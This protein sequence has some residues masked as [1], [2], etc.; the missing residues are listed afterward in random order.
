MSA[1]DT[2][3]PDRAL[4]VLL[5]D[6]QTRLI[7][8]SR[9][10]QFPAGALVTELASGS[11]TGAW[12]TF[13]SLEVDKG[14]WLFIGG[15]YSTLPAV[16]LNNF[17]WWH[18]YTQFVADA[19][20]SPV[21]YAGNGRHYLWAIPRIDNVMASWSVN[22]PVRTKVDMKMTTSYPPMGVNEMYLA[23]IPT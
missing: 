21:H 13:L 22:L 16:T 23:A 17:L 15:Y 7:T 12:Q 18:T 3:E 19:Q 4:E 5:T 9:R 11:I 6:Y 14:R 20:A 2:L 10:A 1:R 8:I